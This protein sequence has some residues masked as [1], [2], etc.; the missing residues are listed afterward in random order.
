MKTR[1]DG[2]RSRK[3]PSKYIKMDRQLNTSQNINSDNSNGIRNHIVCAII[4]L[5]ISAIFFIAGLKWGYSKKDARD[6]LNENN[7]VIASSVD[8]IVG[9]HFASFTQDFLKNDEYLRYLDI[10]HV[11]YKSAL[12][13]L[14]PSGFKTIGIRN[15]SIINPGKFSSNDIEFDFDGS[16]EFYGN[17]FTVDMNLTNIYFKKDNS[18][19]EANRVIDTINNYKVGELYRLDSSVTPGVG[20]LHNFGQ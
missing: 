7:P 8:T 11:L 5:V 15:N 6:A 17:N 3:K 12:E 13:K 14:L 2:N 19:S 20:L 1:T 18:L 16:I 4:T 10:Y 9:S